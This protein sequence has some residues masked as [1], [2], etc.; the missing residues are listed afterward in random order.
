MHRTTRTT[1]LAAAIAAL[2]PSLAFAQDLYSRDTPADMGIQPNPDMG[3]MWL[4]E[5]IWVRTTPDPNYRPFPFTAASP[6]WTPAPHQNPEYRDPR[7]GLPNYV[8]VR[9][10]NIGPGPSTGTEQLRLYWAKASTGSTSKHCQGAAIASFRR[11][12]SW[13]TT[14]HGWSAGG[15]SH[16][17]PR[18]V[19]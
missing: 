10:R 19:A 14:R 16:R 18:A 4:S 2:V 15:Q 7:L 3:P 17:N 11:F 5:D 12:E 13:T 6:P 9:V 8:Y 1:L